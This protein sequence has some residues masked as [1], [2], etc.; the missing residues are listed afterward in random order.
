MSR[1]F[2]DG[3]G[4]SLNREIGETI[5]RDVG[6]TK[7]PDKSPAQLGDGNGTGARLER[8]YLTLAGA[9][10]GRMKNSELRVRCLASGLLVYSTDRHARL[11]PGI[12]ATMMPDD[13]LA[14]NYEDF[15]QPPNEATPLLG[16]DHT[17]WI[18]QELINYD[19]GIQKQNRLR[20]TRDY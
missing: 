14:F 10:M 17:L 16:R 20:S 6:V 3:N 4:R 9:I 1:F 15:F 12:E 5:Q 13:T 11:E 8:I 19:Y 2:Y 7:T 18:A